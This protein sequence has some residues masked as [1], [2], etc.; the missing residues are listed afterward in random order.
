VRLAA[1][2]LLALAAGCAPPGA[3]KAYPG[4]DRSANELAAVETF[5]R[6]E[7][8]SLT[9]NEIT[10]VDGVRFEKRG[11]FATMLPG[12]HSIG[13][14]GTLRVS[15]QVRVQHCVFDLNVDAGCIYRPA[16]PA[17]PRDALDQPADAEWRVTR[18]MTVVVECSEGM[19]SAI[20]VPIDCTSRP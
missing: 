14:R 8:F 15:R 20:Q 4:P 2:A 12:P 17:Y 13:L 18:A 6:S 5:M 1:A 9:D 3:I 10:A 11:Y 19:S 16:V 7:T